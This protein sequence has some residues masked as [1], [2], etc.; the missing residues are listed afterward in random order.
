MGVETDL[1]TETQ[2]SIA[3]GPFE[4]YNPALILGGLEVGVTP[5]EMAHAYNTLAAG[6]QRLSGTMA[7][8][9]GGPVGIIDVYDGG[10]D[11]AERSATSRATRCPTRPA[12]AASTRRSPSRSIDPAVAAEAKSILLDRG[13]AAAPDTWRRPATRPG[14][15]PG[16]PTTTATPGSA[17]RRRRI[18][19]CVWVGYPGHGDADGDRVRRR[20][21]RRRHLPGP[22]LLARGRRLRLDSMATRDDGNEVKA[23]A[24]EVDSAV[25]RARRPTT[26]PSRPSPDRP[27]RP[28]PRDRGPRSRPR[29][30]S[31]SPPHR[32]PTPTGTARG[33]PRRRPA[34]TPA[35]TQR[36]GGR[37]ERG[38]R[39][40][41]L[42]AG[43]RPTAPAAAAARRYALP[44]AQ[45]RHG[46]LGRL[47]DPDPRTRRDLERRSHGAARARSSNGGRSSAAALR[48]RP[49]PS[50]S[51]SLPGPEHS[52]LRGR[53]AAAAGASPRGPRVG[54]S[55][56][57][58]TAA[59]LPSG[60]QTAFSMLWMP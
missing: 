55:A 23:D 11:C 47:R 14:A 56:R 58:S 7:A 13:L 1:S 25:D 6:G 9:A 8:D 24:D 33:P 31:P 5:L 37:R 48:S 12:P 36:R 19:A 3:D 4:P 27:S 35:A 30:P 41:R 42:A 21:G 50:A 22:D 54:S 34:P 57:I 39:L 40:A 2:Y 53:A 16:P 51:V 49:I 18:T 26:P 44:A 45:K 32:R 15:R 28:I 52:S 17:A 46:Q 10:D 20:A 60:S 29:A 43:R 38:R 59:A